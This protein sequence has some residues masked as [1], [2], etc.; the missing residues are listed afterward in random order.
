MIWWLLRLLW[1]L[2]LWPREG[3]AREEGGGWR[4]GGGS[5]VV[6]HVVGKGSL[7]EHRNDNWQYGR[8]MHYQAIT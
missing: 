4:G 7:L 8:Q 6:C 2:G 1:N 5:A 3:G